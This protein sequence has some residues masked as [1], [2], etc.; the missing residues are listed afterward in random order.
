MLQEL[1]PN[2]S[3][4]DALLVLLLTFGSPNGPVLSEHA[5]GSSLR[6][7][8]AELQNWLPISAMSNEEM[9]IMVE[10]LSHEETRYPGHA[11]TYVKAHI[12][13]P[14]GVK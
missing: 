1:N 4:K 10:D 8:L 6:Q 5:G 3:C 9:S 12:W 14:T 11:W 13:S 7:F 2:T